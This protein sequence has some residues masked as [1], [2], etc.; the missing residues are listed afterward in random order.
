MK[1]VASSIICFFVFWSILPSRANTSHSSR[2]YIKEYLT[3]QPDTTPAQKIRLPQDKVDPIRLQ[4][5]A[6]IEKTVQYDP[7]TNRYILIEKIGDDIISSSP[8]TFDEY[9][10]YK[11]KQ[12]QENYFSQLK[13]TSDGT[14]GIGKDPVDKID[15]K[16]SLI[17]RLFGGN[18]VEI[19]PSGFVEVSPGL[20]YQNVK[21]PSL[22]LRQ[23]K[24]TNFDFPMNIQMNLQGKIGQKLDLDMKYNT[25]AT[26]D[27]DNAMK[28]NYNSAEFSDDEILKKIDAGNVSLPMR[29]SLI[30]GA[31]NLF[32]VKAETQFGK[33][34]VTGIASQTRT[35]Q[36]RVE[37]KGGAQLQ[38]FEIQCDEYDENQ[39]YLLGH[40]FRNIFERSM[41]RLPYINTLAK[42][43]LTSVQV[44]VSP[45]PRDIINLRQIVAFSDLGEF[46]RMN[47][48]SPGQWTAGVTPIIDPQYT[49]KL[50]TNQTNT[51]YQQF[52][53]NPSLRQTNKVVAGLQR[54]PFEM[55]IGRDFEVFNGQLMDPREYTV[56]PDLGYVSFRRTIRPNDIV[57]I[58]FKYTFNGKAYKVGEF[59]QEVA[60]DSLSVIVAKLIKP[61]ANRVDIPIWDLM[62]KNF[63]SIRS[64][65]ISE[66][67]FK[68]DILFDDPGAGE[69][70]FLPETE[71]RSIPRWSL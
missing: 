37:L 8:M 70:R 4:D 46:D 40:Y 61:R 29:T 31:Q 50:P 44:W 65:G 23:Q 71:L 22:T 19:K 10:K 48:V 55:S 69:K 53:S 56:H 58:S 35:Q 28:L 13:G 26:F 59:T 54:P 21:N 16:Q 5:P 57:A 68:L 18:T 60:P 9:V 64:F 42:I 15:V 6:I 34:R 66:E 41:V 11:N 47:N 7:E 49:E 43:D 27:F 20:V 12:L 39:H 3:P 67:D 30:Q 36:Q 17:D 38:D 1:S 2:N 63:Y 52:I 14:K 24:Q 25:Q 45:N 51:I 62:M 32:G 33:L